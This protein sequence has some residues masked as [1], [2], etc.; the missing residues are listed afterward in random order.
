MRFDL[1]EP[2]LLMFRDGV[3]VTLLFTVLSLAVALLLGVLLAVLKVQ[4]WRPVRA[5]LRLYTSVFRGVPLM[6]LL[7]MTY[8][9]TPQLTGWAITP[10]E[11]G[12]IT[13]GLNGSATI[14]EVLRG[15]ISAVGAGQWDA[16][17]A[18]GMTYL[19]TMRSVVLPQALRSTAP[20]LVNETI[21]MLKGSSL[22][23]TIGVVDVLKTATTIQSI[24]FRA[25]EPLLV[26]AV[27][28]Y[29]LVLVLSA[30]GRRLEAA[31]A[32]R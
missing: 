31:L 16:S 26:A 24:T 7:F 10:L 11:A 23:S 3:G 30:L 14:S 6:V 29:A 2:Y 25:F 17:R 12:V 22:V 21:T 27:I 4:P 13:F 8:F 18:L 19:Q 5:A 28:Y 1:I 15:G 32:T 20:A 9:A